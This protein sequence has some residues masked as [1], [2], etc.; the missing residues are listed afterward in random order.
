MYHSVAAHYI[1]IGTS[2]VFSLTVWVLDVQRKKEL[3][4]PHSLPLSHSAT[5]EW[6]GYGSLL[7]YYSSNL[8]LTQA[9]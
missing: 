7:K 5:L 9:A 8:S 6:I 4:P 1:A 2:G 3:H